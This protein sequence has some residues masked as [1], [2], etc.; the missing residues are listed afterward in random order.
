MTLGSYQSWQTQG[1]GRQLVEVKDEFM[2]VPLLK[3]LERILQNRSIFEE[4]N[5]TIFTYLIH[6][7]VLMTEVSFL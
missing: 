7:C 6:A 2:Y 5:K 1:T 4:V 3:V